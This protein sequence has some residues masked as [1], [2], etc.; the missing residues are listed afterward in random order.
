MHKTRRTLATRT[1]VDL[2]LCLVAASQALA[3]G[4][5]STV[6]ISRNLVGFSVKV[7]SD[8]ETRLRVL[9]GGMAT[10]TLA[11]GFKFGLV[12]VVEGTGLKLSV[13]HITH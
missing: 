13:A 1:L 9:N 2:F 7:G 6:P 10:I 3:Q 8:P 4:E 11:D 5:A 12:P